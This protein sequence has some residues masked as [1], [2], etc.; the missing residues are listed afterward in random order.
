VEVLDGIASTDRVV[1]TG[2]ILLR[3]SGQ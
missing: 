1:A 2:G 3:Q